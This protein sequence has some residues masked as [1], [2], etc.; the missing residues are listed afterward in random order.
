MGHML[1]ADCASSA[2]INAFV[3]A[4]ALW[5]QIYVEVR[6]FLTKTQEHPALREIL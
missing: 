6:I 5:Y 3:F 1:L 4:L 2:I